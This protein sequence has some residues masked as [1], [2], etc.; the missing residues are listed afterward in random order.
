MRI[1]LGIVLWWVGSVA[2]A[3]ITFGTALG[4]LIE[5]SL[6][7]FVFGPVVG[8]PIMLGCWALCF[9]VAGSFLRPPSPPM[10]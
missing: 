7:G 4:L 5:G 6:K 2:G 1:R 10:R 8:I 3:L 9:I